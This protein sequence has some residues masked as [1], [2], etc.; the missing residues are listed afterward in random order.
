MK[1][2]EQTVRLVMPVNR[3]GIPKQHLQKDKALMAKTQAMFT[4]TRTHIP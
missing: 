1:S 3:Q 4:D 2:A